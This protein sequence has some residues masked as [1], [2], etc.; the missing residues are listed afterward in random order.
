MA[1]TPPSACCDI[2]TTFGHHH[3]VVAVDERCGGTSRSARRAPSR[4]A[5]RSCRAPSAAGCGAPSRASRT[6]PRALRQTGARRSRRRRARRTTSGSV[7]RW[8]Q[9]VARPVVL[10]EVPVEV[11]DV[12]A[13]AHHLADETLGR[14]PA[15]RRPVGSASSAAPT[16]SIGSSRPEVQRRREQGVRHPAVA[17]HDGV[18]VAARTSAAGGRRS[19][20]AR[21]SASVAG[22]GERAAARRRRRTRTPSAPNRS[23]SARTSA[24]ISSSVGQARLRDAQGR[25]APR[26]RLAVLGVEVPAAAD[27][28]AAV[29]QHAVP[30]GRRGRSPPSAAAAGPGRPPTP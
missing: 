16:T 2:P 13:P 4:A 3:P 19:P 28:L 22:G 12:V 29:H 8:S 25:R 9:H 15:A 14:R 7:R 24:S 11:P 27:R 6:E 30:A 26:W 17:A 18:L 23:R 1:R 21:R 10:T 20:R 5:A